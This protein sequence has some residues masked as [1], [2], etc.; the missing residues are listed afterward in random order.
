MKKLLIVDDE[1]GI[2]E[3]VEGFF[4]DEGFE[5]YAAGSGREG[6]RLLREKKPDVV[7]IDLK[8]PDIS[9]LDVL[10]EAKRISPGIRTIVNTG[11]V[12]QALTDKAENSGCDVFLHKPFDLAKLKQEIDRLL[13]L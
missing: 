5:V 12:D 8:L 1:E 2:L 3:E 7:M 6:V 10:K 13:A 9:G 4:S 11:Y